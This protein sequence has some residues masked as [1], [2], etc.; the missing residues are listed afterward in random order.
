[1]S[2]RPLLC[3]AMLTAHITS[4]AE[5]Y[6]KYPP[7]W[8]VRSISIVRGALYFLHPRY[9]QFL[10]NM[11]K[12]ETWLKTVRF[13]AENNI[14]QTLKCRWQKITKKKKSLD[15]SMVLVPRPVHLSILTRSKGGNNSSW[16]DTAEVWYWYEVVIPTKRRSTC[17]AAT[18]NVLVNL[19]V[20]LTCAR[21]C[22]R[23]YHTH[24][25]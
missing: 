22:T 20:L 21:S 23:M 18:V 16:A 2:W 6:H 24:I 19:L 10:W 1:M 11:Q 17:T 4:A 8:P 13:L 5:T 9:M 12:R 14:P 15:A 3:D 7:C 25:Y